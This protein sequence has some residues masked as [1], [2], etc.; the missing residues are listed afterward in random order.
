MSKKEKTGEEYLTNQGPQG[1][2]HGGSKC[3]KPGERQ[4]T[5]SPPASLVETS[6]VHTL[7]SDFQPPQLGDDT[8]VWFQ[9]VKVCSGHP[10]KGIHMVILHLIF[11]E[12]MKCF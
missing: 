10:G 1:T 3:W 5:D 8:V 4:G 6:P 2:S 11:E 9:N 12:L 7:I